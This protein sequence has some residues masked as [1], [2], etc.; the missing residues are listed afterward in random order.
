MF[1]W[2]VRIAVQ[3][4]MRL[5]EIATLRIRHVDIE[6]RVVRLEHTKNSSPRTVPLTAEATRVFTEA[7]ANPVIA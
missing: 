3:T 7:L 4:G 1:G 6:R 5:S 2:I